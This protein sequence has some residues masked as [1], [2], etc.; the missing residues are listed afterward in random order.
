VGGWGGVGWDGVCAC[1]CIDLFIGAQAIGF[2]G[3]A[4]VTMQVSP[5]CL[6]RTVII[7]QVSV[8]CQSPQQDV[9]GRVT[10]NS[11][12]MD[13]PY[14]SVTCVSESGARHC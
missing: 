3:F 14:N 11:S 9:C 10:V 2:N 12:L 8:P 6:N 5:V 1:S 4:L 13:H 7:M